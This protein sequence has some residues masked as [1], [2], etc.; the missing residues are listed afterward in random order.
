MLSPGIASSILLILLVAA[1]IGF[2]NEHHARR[3]QEKGLVPW[4]WTTL[5]AYVCFAIAIAGLGMHG[6]E[7]LHRAGAPT[8]VA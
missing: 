2:A 4:R 8:F 7:V 1:V 5:V 6:F 3:R